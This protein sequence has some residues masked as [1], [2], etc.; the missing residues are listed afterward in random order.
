MQVQVQV[1]SVRRA[2]LLQR[3]LP[4]RR[5]P[6][7]PEANLAESDSRSPFHGAWEL[8]TLGGSSLLTYLVFWLPPFWLWKHDPFGHGALYLG[9]IMGWTWPAFWRYAAMCIVPFLLYLLALRLVPNLPQRAALRVVVLIGVLAPLTLLLTYPALAADPFGWLMYGRTI[10]EYGGNPYIDV[11]TAFP[12]DVYYPPVGADWRGMPAPYGPLA[13]WLTAGVTAVAGDH[14]VA[15]LLLLK[16]LMIGCFLAVGALI[17]RLARALHPDNPTHGTVALLAWSWNPMLITHIAL[18]AHNDVLM[19]LPLLGALLAARSQRWLLAF[20]LLSLA[21]LVKF[22]PLLLGP[23]FL[24]AAWPA[25]RDR[26]RRWQV[27]GGMAA[28]ALLVLLL[29]APLW[30]GLDTLNSVRDQGELYTSSPASLLRQLLRNDWLRPLSLA[31]FGGGYLVVL[32]RVRGLEERCWWVLLL[33]L[34][35]LSF[36]TKGWYIAWPLALGAAIGGWPLRTSIAASA[37]V[38]VQ[39]GSAWAWEMDWFHLRTVHGFARWD[40]IL[41]LT[42]YLPW[43]LF[44]ILWL[45]RLRPAHR[46]ATS[47][48]GPGTEP[49]A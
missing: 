16:L 25:L 47:V 26:A 40:W 42:L 35:T 36:W 21:V 43:L 22:I 24:L 10:S 11:A 29:Y 41:T 12:N 44:P 15:A 39:N 17:W 5:R 7:A 46:A 8:L 2:R 3:A 23:L 20:P 27:L 30:V 9:T 1:R 37:G 28:G 6:D 19:L 4:G 14:P 32:R 34:C 49:A 48:S 18:D 33:Y 45:N 13:I 38:F 31:A